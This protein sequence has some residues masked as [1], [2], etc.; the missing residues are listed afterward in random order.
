MLERPEHLRA[1]TTPMNDVLLNTVNQIEVAVGMS[2]LGYD[3][4]EI[5]ESVQQ[6]TG[7]QPVGLEELLQRADFFC[8]FV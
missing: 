6:E 5:P 7:V 8:P 3:V 4:R 1:G 2:V